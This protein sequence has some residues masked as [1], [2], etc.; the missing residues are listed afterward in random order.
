MGD[1]SERASVEATADMRSC[2]AECSERSEAIDRERE[3]GMRRTAWKQVSDVGRP[4]VFPAK[5]RGL[6]PPRDR[7]KYIDLFGLNS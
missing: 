7:N 2:V 1:V 3:R 6:F 5:S 4:T